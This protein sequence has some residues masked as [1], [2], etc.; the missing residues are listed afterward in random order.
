MVLLIEN[1]IGGTLPFFPSRETIVAKKK[2]S[3]LRKQE[4]FR[5]AYGTETI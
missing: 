2:L 1:L 3:L 4:W 5:T